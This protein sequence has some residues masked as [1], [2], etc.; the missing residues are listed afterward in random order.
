MDR[1]L[2]S[3]KFWTAA[4]D[5]AASVT[6]Y[7]VVKYASPS[8]VEDVKFLIAAVQ[9]VIAL[10]IAAWAHEDAQK[11]KYAPKYAYMGEIGAAI[12][13]AKVEVTGSNE[14]PQAAP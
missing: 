6:L 5:F 11:A 1:L 3:A 4:L 2:K 12:Q 10:V 9:P 7:F 14:K 13:K 8:A